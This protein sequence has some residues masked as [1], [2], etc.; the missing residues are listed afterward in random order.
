MSG[1]YQRHPTIDDL[2]QNLNPLQITLAHRNQSHPQS[3]RSSK[4]GES[5]ILTLQKQDTLTLRLHAM[6]QLFKDE[7]K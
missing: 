5:D 4:P 1:R 7:T 3:P 6:S 2:R